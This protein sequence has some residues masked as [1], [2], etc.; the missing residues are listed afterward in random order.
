MNISEF[1]EKYKNY[2]E[3]GFEG[4]S[5]H[6]ENVID[7]LDGVFVDIVTDFPDFKYAQIKLKFDMVRF[8][9]SLPFAIERKIEDE[10]QRILK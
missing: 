4:L 8:Y 10:I 1:N 6:D 7:F 9:S 2:I 5:I 3:E